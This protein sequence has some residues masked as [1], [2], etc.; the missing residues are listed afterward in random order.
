M[1]ALGGVPCP[2]TPAGL[3]PYFPSNNALPRT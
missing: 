3:P 2:N 1:P